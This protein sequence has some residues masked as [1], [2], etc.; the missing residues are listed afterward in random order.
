[1]QFNLIILTKTKE[2]DPLLQ[3]VRIRWQ[4]A[5][6]TA[7]NIL[8]HVIVPTEDISWQLATFTHALKGPALACQIMPLADQYFCTHFKPYELST[9]NQTL[10]NNK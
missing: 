3:I 5:P 8:M 1:M 4:N 6:N 10:I 7:T 9:N 2:N